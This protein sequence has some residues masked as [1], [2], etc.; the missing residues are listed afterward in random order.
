MGM[1]RSLLLTPSLPQ[2]TWGLLKGLV[3]V[4]ELIPTD[5][6]LFSIF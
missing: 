4:K 2:P 5:F 1:E 6:K 3:K